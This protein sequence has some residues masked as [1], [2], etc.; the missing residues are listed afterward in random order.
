LAPGSCLI[1]T[2]KGTVDASVQ[3]QIKE[4]KKTLE[5]A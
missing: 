5:I 1:E 3:T 4:L 2:D